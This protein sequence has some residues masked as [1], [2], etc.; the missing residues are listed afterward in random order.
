MRAFSIL[1]T[2]SLF[3]PVSAQNGPGGVGT[4]ATNVLWLRGDK[5]V[6]VSG[7]A[8]TG[9]SDGSGNGH[10]ASPAS[11]PVRP[12]LATGALNGYPTLSFDGI[13]DELR[14]PDANSLD[15]TQWDMFIVC[16]ATTP[17][18]NNVWLSKGTN[19]QPNYA[20]WSNATNALQMP[21]YDVWNALSSPG[22]SNNATASS[23]NLLQYN[24]TIIAVL[25]PS[26]T[27][28]R[29]GSSIYNDANLLRLPQTNGNALYIGNTQGTTGWNLNGNIAEV[30]LYKAGLTAVQRIIVNNY[31][32]AK[33]ALSLGSGDVYTQDNVANG[34]YDHDV[35]GIG[36]VNSSAIQNDSRGTG[37]VQ[38]SGPTNLGDNEFLFW[39]HDNGALGT[40]GSTDYPVSLQGRWFR[41]WRV[42]ETNAT[43]T[44]VDVGAVDITFD[45][46][47][48]GAVTAS[49]L[50]LLVDANNNDIFADDTP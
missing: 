49:D 9:W 3:V 12:T 15:M 4:A 40:Y 34:N 32:A 45:L 10:L 20:M 7:T 5:G 21:I 19:A 27:I 14:I 42:S 36:R 38:V 50:R 17:K 46:T 47:G 28:Y 37:I 8:V 11:I 39:G 23:Y 24:N 22:T 2:F 26:R 41:E 48:L 16:A 31:L 33:Y 44:A 35:A 6:T 1:L 13:D 29:N 18:S 30:I 43:G 25:F